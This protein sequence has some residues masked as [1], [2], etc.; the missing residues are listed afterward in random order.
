VQDPILPIDST[1]RRIVPSL[2]GAGYAVTYV[3]FT[4][5]HEVPDAMASQAGQW[6]VR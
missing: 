5:G 2:R 3:E 4:G 6:L 1:S